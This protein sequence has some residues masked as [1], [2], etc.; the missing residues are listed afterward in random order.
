MAIPERVS[1]IS[2]ADI[3]MYNETLEISWTAVDG[4]ESYRLDASGDN[5]NSFKKVYNGTDT[6]YEFDVLK[7]NYSR[8]IF[9]VYAENADGVS[10][11]A[12]SKEITVIDWKIEDTDNGTMYLQPFGLVI[13]SASS[14]VD[15]VPAV[16]E[17][18]ETIAGLDGEIPIDMK[19][20]PRLFDLVTFMKGE[21]SSVKERE[22]FIKETS[23][24]INRSVREVRYLLYHGYLFGVKRTASAPQRF[25][26]RINL[27]I[28][29]KAYDVFGYSPAQNVLYGDGI[30]VNDGDEVCYPTFILKDEQNNPTITVNG[31]NY[32][33]AIDALDGDTIYIDCEKEIV[34]REREGVRTY[35]SGAYYLDFPA[36]NVGEN[37][38]SG[39]YAVKW[40]NKTFAI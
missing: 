38:V 22:D 4:A 26:N 21:F 10:D 17:T 6:K 24:H 33:I 11:F 19:Y 34:I 2:V 31:T 3:V 13:D 18:A 15:D 20:S 28:S 30:C 12:E 29:L 35:V 32:Q 37:T 7:S 27:D 8:I 9:R 1:A 25:P 14:K 39:C 36:F 40:R 16:R 23:R 5:G